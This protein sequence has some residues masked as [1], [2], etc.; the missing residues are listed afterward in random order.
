MIEN[1]IDVDAKQRDLDSIKSFE[2]SLQTVTREQKD[3]FIG[4]FTG[5]VQLLQEMLYRFQER[6]VD[7]NTEWT[8]WWAYGWFKEVMRMVSVCLSHIRYIYMFDNRF[9]CGI[10]DFYSLIK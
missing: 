8:Y 9:V 2:T 7:P 1:I 6:G 10:G 3:V 5:F 4:V